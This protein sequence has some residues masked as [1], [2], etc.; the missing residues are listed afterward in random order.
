MGYADNTEKAIAFGESYVKQTLIPA[1]YANH[2]EGEELALKGEPLKGAPN[3]ASG[4]TNVDRYR[5]KVAKNKKT[6][7]KLEAERIALNQAIGKLKNPPASWEELDEY[8]LAV[9]KRH[10][11]SEIARCTKTDSKSFVE[12]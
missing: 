11:R 8:D 3:K 12:E 1:L 6:F 4:K 2:L 7:E 10:F 5:E 9:L